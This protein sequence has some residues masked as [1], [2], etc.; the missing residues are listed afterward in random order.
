MTQGDRLRRAL[1]SVYDKTGLPRLAA[2]CTQRGRADRVDRHVPRPRS[3][4]PACR[5]RAVEE[6]TGFPECLD[7]RVKTLHPAVHAGL[8][9]DLAKDSHREQLAELGIEPFELLV[10]NLYP[11]EQT[12][13][14]GA[15][16]AECVEQIDIGGPAMVRAAAKN[17]ATVAVITSPD[18]YPDVIAALADGGFTLEQRRRLA[19]AGLRAHSRLRRGGLVLVRRAPTRR[20]RWPPR[21][22]GRTS[23]A[24]L[25]R[26]RTCCGT[27]RT[28]ISGAAL[29][30]QSGGRRQPE[31]P[32]GRD[33]QC[34]GAA[35]QGHVLQQLRG[36]GRGQAGRVRFHR[37][38]RGDH[39]A[40]QPVRYRARRR[41]GGGAPQGARLR[42][43]VRVRRRHRRERHGDGGDGR[44]RSPRSSP[45]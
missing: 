5:L 2:R 33:R 1:I 11:F 39:E 18:S 42:S 22:A 32:A 23:P 30:L 25:D 40:R 34:R 8:L 38:V 44:A 9:A 24:R 35:R 13:A 3:R 6:L 43:G 16:A 41:P 17:H 36:R 31:L 37:A 28:R 12:V 7:G 4:P 19:G 29:Y 15:S 14:S 10:S 26:A 20:T 45:R 27:A 21:R